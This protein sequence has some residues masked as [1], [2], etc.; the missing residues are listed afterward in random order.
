M[1]MLRTSS[2]IKDF[3]FLRKHK[4]TNYVDKLRKNRVFIRKILVCN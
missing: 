1:G 3:I 2:A 4:V